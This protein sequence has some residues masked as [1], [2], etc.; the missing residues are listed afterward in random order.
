VLDCAGTVATKETMKEF[1]TSVKHDVLQEFT[2]VP[3]VIKLFAKGAHVTEWISLNPSFTVTTHV[4]I[5]RSHSSIIIVS[6]LK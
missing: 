3:D 4:K 5:V 2:I 6:L 1:V